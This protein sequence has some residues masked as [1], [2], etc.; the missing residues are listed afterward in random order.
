MIPV[1]FRKGGA[2]ISTYDFYDLASGTGIKVF[3]A[4]DVNCTVQDVPG[5]R[6]LS[7]EKFYSA[8]GYSDSASAAGDY[9]FDVEFERP[10]TIKGDCIVNIPVMAYNSGGAGYKSPTFTAGIKHWDGTTETHLISGAALVSIYATAGGTAD[11]ITAIKVNIPKTHFKKGETLRLNVEHTTAPEGAAELAIAHDPIG[12][13]TIG[14][15]LAGGGTWT[16]T[17]ALTMQVPLVVDI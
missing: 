13:L 8:I 15:G 12:R 11:R 14:T 7:T 3:Y 9:D 10:T 16:N 2:A 17:T 4:G 5:T 6:T 1:K